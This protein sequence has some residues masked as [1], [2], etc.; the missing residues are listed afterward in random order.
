VALAGALVALAGALVAP[1][2][3]LV[4]LLAITAE[5]DCT[6]PVVEEDDDD[7]ELVSPPV[8]QPASTTLAAVPNS[9]RLKTQCMKTPWPG[10]KPAWRGLVLREWPYGTVGLPRSAQPHD[11]Q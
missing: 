3:A 7:E 2:A 1:E 8:G 6:P 4:A 9:A 11:A 5:E 10:I